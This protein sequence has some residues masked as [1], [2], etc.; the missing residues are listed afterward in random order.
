M[1][2]RAPIV[3]LLGLAACASPGN[4]R[5]P[6]VGVDS[7]SVLPVFPSN[8]YTVA[9]P[10]T[11]TGLRVHLPDVSHDA[12]FGAFKGLDGELN[13]LDG[14]GTSA[15]LWVRFDAPIDPSGLPSWDQSIDPAS[16]VQIIRLSDGVRERFETTYDG[17]SHT[18]FVQPWG[19]LRSASLYALVILDVLHDL[20]GRKL[21]PAGT[22][23]AAGSGSEVRRWLGK[24]DKTVLVSVFTTQSSSET[25]GLLAQRPVPHTAAEL[26][27][28]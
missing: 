9:A 12:V 11:R 27:P 1:R 15:E 2:I 10:A 4:G 14:F 26:P 25:L 3:F 28:V 13:S 7:G 18:L 6:V 5:E 22:T 16:T 17:P 21:K 19:A 20:D 8:R 23:W 24:S